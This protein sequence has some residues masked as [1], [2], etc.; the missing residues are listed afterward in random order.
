VELGQCGRQDC[1][2]RAS[3]GRGDHCW[4]ESV[5]LLAKAEGITVELKDPQ[6]P[7]SQV[8]SAEMTLCGRLIPF[9]RQARET[10]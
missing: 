7:Y 9:S 10:V 1:I 2:L 3:W 5:R 4:Q 6:N 8:L